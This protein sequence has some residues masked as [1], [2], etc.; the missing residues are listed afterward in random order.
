MLDCG[1]DSEG[2]DIIMDQLKSIYNNTF[3]DLHS[4]PI[5]SCFAMIASNVER[6]IVADLCVKVHSHY[7]FF[8]IICVKR[9]KWVLY[10]FFAFDATSHRHNVAIWSKHKRTRNR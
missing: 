10:P 4:H 2:P 9:K 7:V 1:L 8:Y 6:I 5:H 3:K